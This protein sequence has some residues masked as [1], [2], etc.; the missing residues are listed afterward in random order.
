MAS[1]MAQK[2]SKGVDEVPK[3]FG[4]RSHSLSIET[5]VTICMSLQETIIKLQNEAHICSEREMVIQHSM[6][7]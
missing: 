2:T 1:N 7:L 6:N 3:H 4:G 5:I